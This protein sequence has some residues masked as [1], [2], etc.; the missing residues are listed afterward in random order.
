MVTQLWFQ[1]RVALP[2]CRFNHLIAVNLCPY[3]IRITDI[4]YFISTRWRL[5]SDSRKL[6]INISNQRTL[7]INKYLQPKIIT[8]KYTE[9]NYGNCCH[10]YGNCCQWVWHCYQMLMC[11]INFV[12]HCISS[13]YK[14]KHSSETNQLKILQNNSGFCMYS[15]DSR[16][17]ALI[18]KL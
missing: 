13:V 11:R 7:V 4:C 1:I 8:S 3:V 15:R 18:T 2:L 5:Q 14:P 17:K 10:D 12:Q 6:V 16:Q 9:W